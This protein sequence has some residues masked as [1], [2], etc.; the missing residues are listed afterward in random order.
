MRTEDKGYSRKVEVSEISD[1]IANS[2]RVDYYNVQIIGDLDLNEANLKRGENNKKIVASHIIIRDSEINGSLKFNDTIFWNSIEFSGTIFNQNV[3]FDNTQF[4]ENVDFQGSKFKEEVNFNS[5]QFNKNVSF[6]HAHFK[7]P[8]QF[9]WAKFESNAIFEWTLFFD[10]AIFFE[11]EFYHTPNFINSKFSKEKDEKDIESIIQGTLELEH[12]ST[13]E[14]ATKQSNVPESDKNLREVPLA[15]KI[16]TVTSANAVG[17]VQ[18]DTTREGSKIKAP[19]I[20]SLPLGDRWSKIDLLEFSDYAEALADFIRNKNT[21]E[22][23][24]IGIDAA[25]GTGKTTLMHMIEAILN[26]Q[27]DAQTF[28]DKYPTVWFNA[29]KYDREKSLWSA[30]ALEILT[31]VRSQLDVRQRMLFWLKLDIK[32]FD[33][34]SMLQNMLRSLFYLVGVIWIGIFGLI[35]ASRL[36]GITLHESLKIIWQNIIIAGFLVGIPALYAAGRTILNRIAKPFDLNISQYIRDPKYE[37]NVGFLAQFEEDFKHVIDI[38]TE[39]GDRKLVVFIDDLD[40]CTPPHAADIIEAINVL[41]DADHC[42]F[43]IGMDSKTV[44]SSIRAK[45]RDMEDYDDDYDS[46]GLTLGQRFLEKIIQ[47]N[48]HIPKSDPTVVRTFIDATL[49]PTKE[50]PTGS[51]EEISKENTSKKKIQEATEQIKAKQKKGKSLDDAAIE[52]RTSRSD[53]SED[54]FIEAKEEAFAEFLNESKEVV[55]AANDAIGYLEPNPRKI[56]RFINVFRLQALIANRRGLLESGVIRLD[57]LAKW[58]VVTMRWPQMIEMIASDR[59]SANY[60]DRDAFLE[61][62]KGKKMPNEGNLIDLMNTISPADFRRLSEYSRLAEMTEVN[63]EQVI[64]DI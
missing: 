6:F 37:Q 18:K 21:K 27:E 43:V 40:R 45:Y 64:F 1:K 25:W 4:S 47:I 62:L 19:K 41:L 44:A 54:E 13:E 48:F 39:E 23:I 36:Q 22:P 53:L 33:R 5:A 56:K 35:L 30:L 20:A 50:S 46:S 15:G 42:I 14:H 26:P 3:T 24:T 59:N 34:M 38:V 60:M 63:V 29:W 16:G 49:N 10:S 11:A 52:I 55:Q 57:L 61:D 58:I 9:M 32:R 8:V 31:Q 17:E 2:E 12:N 28:G 51:L 7:K